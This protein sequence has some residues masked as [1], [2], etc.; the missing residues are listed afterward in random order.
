MGVRVGSGADWSG[1]APAVVL[2]ANDFLF[3]PSPAG[4]STFDVTG[5]G[6]RFLMVQR[7]TEGDTAPR[8]I[9]VVQHWDEEL[10]RLMSTE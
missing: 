7:V 8:P 3:S 9:V 6:Q 5:D 2:E 10:K 4:A 1:S